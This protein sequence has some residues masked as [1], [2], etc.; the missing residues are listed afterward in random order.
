MAK[1]DYYEVL[2]VGRNASAAELKSAYRKLAKQQHPDRNAGDSAAELRFK[3]VSEAYEV[4]K[5]DQKRAAYEQ[6]GHAAFEGGGG[7][8]AGFEF[9][10][11]AD[12][13]DDL[14][15]DFMGGGRQRGGQ[16]R[17]ADLRYNLEISLED[18]FGGKQTQIRVPTT[19]RCDA[20]S[21]SGSAKGVAPDVCPSCRSAGRVRGARESGSI[22]P[23]RS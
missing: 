4:L 21:G 13:F 18:A 22:V 14:F 1:R 9:G 11:F 16:S 15:G 12:V 3:E 19:V 17:G 2:G 20:C 10:S 5:D 6:F 8:R 23:I 7:G